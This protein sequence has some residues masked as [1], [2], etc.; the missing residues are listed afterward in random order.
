MTHDRMSF[1]DAAAYFWP[2]VGWISVLVGLP[3]EL[4]AVVAVGTG[5]A[6]AGYMLRLRRVLQA[7]PS[8]R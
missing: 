1:G 6:M 7:A 5:F 8:D 3:L 4:G 2:P